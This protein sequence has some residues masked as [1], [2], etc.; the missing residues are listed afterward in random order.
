MTAAAVS[1][2]PLLARAA[3]LR[4]RGL[5]WDAVGGQ[6]HATPPALDEPPDDGP[7]GAMVLRGPDGPAGGW[8]GGAEF[9]RPSPSASEVG[10]KDLAGARARTD[11]AG[12]LP[13]IGGRAAGGVGAAGVEPGVDGL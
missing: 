11:G 3:R 9:F 10:A 7:G 4:A 8:G 6:L 2:A 12:D 13:R 5:S 1:P